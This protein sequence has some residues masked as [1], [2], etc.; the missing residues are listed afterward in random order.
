MFIASTWSRVH[1]FDAVT[2]EEIWA[3]DPQVP[4]AWSRWACCDVVNRGVAVYG[5][6]VYIGSLDGRLIALD[7]AT[8]TLVWEVDTL[9][10]RERPYTITGAPG[11]ARQGLHRQ[12]GRGVRRPGLRNRVRRRDRRAGLAVLHGARRPLAAV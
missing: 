3:Y 8:G 6:R 1:A 2:G 11:G 4:R 12:W 7:A 5:G 10:D 9:I